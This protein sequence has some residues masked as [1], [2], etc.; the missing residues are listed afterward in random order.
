MNRY[1]PNRR[2]SC[3]RC[4]AQGLMGAAVLITLG[5]LFLLD[6]FWVV[7]FGESFPALLIVIGLMLYLG[8]SAS[9]EGHVQAASAGAIPP[10]P[11][12]IPH[13]QHGPEVNQ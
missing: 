3:P 7:R 10:P 12:P 11:P 1:I 9:T 6:E 13:D 4:R 8:R 5:V 2:C